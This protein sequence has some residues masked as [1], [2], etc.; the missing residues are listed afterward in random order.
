MKL[1]LDTCSFI[2]FI[3]DAPGLSAKARSAILDPANTVYLSAV[4]AWEIGRKYAKGDLALPGRPENV[5]PQVRTDSGIASLPL[6]EEEAISA[7][8]L[9]L[10]HRDPFDRM[11]IAQALVQ[12]MVVVTPD[13]AFEPYPVRLLW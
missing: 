2:W 8:K 9:P 3:A 4:S 5:I 6:S 12:G 10:L 7:E 11:I 13:K 1:L